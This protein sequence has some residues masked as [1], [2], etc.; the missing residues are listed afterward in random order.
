MLKKNQPVKLKEGSTMWTVYQSISNGSHS[1]SQILVNTALRLGKVR[2]ALHN[3]RFVGMIDLVE[4]D[5]RTRY[6]LPDQERPRNAEI[7]KAENVTPAQTLAINSI[8]IT[9][10]QIVERLQKGGR[11]KKEAPNPVMWRPKSPEARNKFIEMGGS[12]WLDRIM[13]GLTK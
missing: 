9:S 7:G 12:K 13:E 4:V 8:C 11:P 5:G 6:Y 3:L 1:Q 2:S 10:S